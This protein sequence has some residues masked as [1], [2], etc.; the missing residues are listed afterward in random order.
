MASRLVRSLG[1]VGLGG[2]TDSFD[3][4]LWFAIQDQRV[5]GLDVLEGSRPTCFW[6]VSFDNLEQPLVVTRNAESLAIAVSVFAP[7][8]WRYE[9]PGLT[10]RERRALK[11]YEA[12][13]PT[14]QF[15]E[16][17]G[18]WVAPE[19]LAF[20]CKWDRQTLELILGNG[21]SHVRLPSLTEDLPQVFGAVAGGFLTLVQSD[22]E[23]AMV[24]ILDESL[25]LRATVT[26]PGSRRVRTRVTGRNLAMGCDLGRVVV[27]D[28]DRGT[29]R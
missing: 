2:W 19:G 12:S 17:L 27:L 24:R 14:T 29:L 16:W 15:F 11:T 25:A 23:K 18:T 20:W 7:E 1:L 4:S 21:R 22:A 6:S 3:G 28:L 8:V 5:I 10:L 26:F 13:T 9:L